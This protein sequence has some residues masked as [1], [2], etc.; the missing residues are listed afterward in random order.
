MEILG[1]ATCPL[2]HTADPAVT[3]DGL[4]KGADW[5]CAR[6]GHRWNAVRLATAAAYA[7]WAS[8]HDAVAS[9]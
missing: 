2:C 9:R 7:A 3:N 4:A 6:C 8:E 5:Q 1:F